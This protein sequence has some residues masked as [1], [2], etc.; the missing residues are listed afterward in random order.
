M[1]NQSQD[2]V[3]LAAQEAVG[4][5]RDSQGTANLLGPIYNFSR[6]L[7]SDPEDLKKLDLS[8]DSKLIFP[9]P[10][11]PKVYRGKYTLSRHMRLECGKVP[12]NK[13]QI[14][15]Q[16]FTHKHRLLSHIRSIHASFLAAAYS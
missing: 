5:H 14:C 11:C 7:T 3:F 8:I 4:A 1:G 16:L 2:E 10:N 6:Y 15:G 9:C 12:T 13:C